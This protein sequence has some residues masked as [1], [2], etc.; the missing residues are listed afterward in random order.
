[1][2]GGQADAR[3]IGGGEDAYAR[4]SRSNEDEVEVLGVGG[5]GRPVVSMPSS[6]FFA[7]HIGQHPESRN[8]DL[9]QAAADGAYKDALDMGVAM[10]R[11]MPLSLAI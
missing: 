10:D 4:T 7:Q 8:D 6:A 2:H 1:M 9:E 11:P 3:R 5:R